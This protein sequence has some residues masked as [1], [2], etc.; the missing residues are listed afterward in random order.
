ML[1]R[2][3]LFAVSGLPLLPHAGFRVAARNESRLLRDT[4]ALLPTLDAIEGDPPVQIFGWT[5]V[6][7]LRDASPA[8]ELAT[9]VADGP[10][11]NP[12]I[13]TVP[14]DSAIHINWG[15]GLADLLGFDIDDIDQ[16]LIAFE[17]RAFTRV[18]HGRFDVERIGASLA[19]QR[20]TASTEGNWTLLASPGGDEYDLDSAITAIVPFEFNYLLISESTIVTAGARAAIDAV[21]TAAESG[22][23]LNTSL[24]AS[25]LP[26][27]LEGATAAS[28]Y[29]GQMLRID[30][31]R[32]GTVEFEVDLPRV[33]WFAADMTYTGEGVR[34]RILVEFDRDSSNRAAT[35]IRDRLDTGESTVADGPYVDLFGQVEVT[36]IPDTGIVEIAGA[37]P[38]FSQH[39]HLAVSGR[40]LLFIATE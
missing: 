23:N 36:V 19:A 4:L 20:Y 11:R 24:D 26:R 8:G 17:V 22:R 37:D 7:A 40:D 1:S 34:T 27:H 12:A 38:L 33:A 2:R 32:M 39:W 31:L 21:L 35:V 3:A 5:D 10:R 16:T 30:R 13:N 9:P 29:D 18:Y 14:L 28:L 6:Q 15:S 25:S